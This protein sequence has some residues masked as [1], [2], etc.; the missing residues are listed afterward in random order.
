[1]TRLLRALVTQEVCEALDAD[2]FAL[3]SLGHFLRREH[4][5]GFQHGASQRRAD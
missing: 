5:H 3:G 1:M 2:S 4:A